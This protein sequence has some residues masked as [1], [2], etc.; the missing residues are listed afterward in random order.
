MELEIYGVEI[1]L[2]D[3][4]KRIKHGKNSNIFNCFEKNGKYNKK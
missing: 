3:A 4:G 2:M 1:L